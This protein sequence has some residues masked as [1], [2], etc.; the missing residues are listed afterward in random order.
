MRTFPSPRIQKASWNVYAAANSTALPDVI[1][2]LF[3]QFPTLMDGG[4][5]GYNFVQSGIDNPTPGP[6]APGKVSGMTGSYILQDD[7]DPEAIPRL[8]GPIEEAIRERWG[9]A[10][11]STLN[12]SSYDSFLGWYRENLD[13]ESAGFDVYLR[14]RLLDREALE[15]DERALRR[16]LEPTLGDPL[17]GLQAFMVGGEGVRDAVPRGGGNSVLPAWRNAYVHASKST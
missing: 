7:D 2:Y 10:V 13:P 9:G 6:G 4:L 14:S 5:S 15:G 1:A 11:A 17:S 16:A 3:A 12:V 8:I